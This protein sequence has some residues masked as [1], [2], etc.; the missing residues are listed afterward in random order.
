MHNYCW[1]CFQT[2]MLE[3]ILQSPSDQSILK[4]I[5]PEYS[6]AGRMLK[7]KL[8]PYG[9]LMQRTDLLEKTLMLRK[10]EGRRLKANGE[11]GDKGQDN[12]LGWRH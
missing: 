3:K 12:H 2:V 10:T 1:V 5:S 7:L 6:W 8:K 11:G 4:E 9:H